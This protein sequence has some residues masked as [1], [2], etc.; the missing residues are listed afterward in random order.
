MKIVN[1]PKRRLFFCHIFP[2]FLE[3]HTVFLC[4]IGFV[5]RKNISPLSMFP[6]FKQGLSDQRNPVE[7]SAGF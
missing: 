1:T 3:I 2:I 7:K 6:F 4:Q 5:W